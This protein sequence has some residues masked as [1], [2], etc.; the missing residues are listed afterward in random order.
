MSM[1]L[2]NETIVSNR[3]Y[4]IN[5]IVKINDIIQID[6]QIKTYLFHH[7]LISGPFKRID[8]TKG[9]E[10]KRGNNFFSILSPIHACKYFHKT[11]QYLNTKHLFLQ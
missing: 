11:V 9:E 8:Q 7:F 6:M 3:F 1:T 10:S 2:Q 4:E 5:D